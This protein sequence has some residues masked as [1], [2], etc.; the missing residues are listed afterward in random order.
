MN[1]IF[2][3]LLISDISSK[4]AKVIYFSEHDNLITSDMNSMGKSVLMKSLYHALG[5]DS[6]FDKN[7]DEQNVLFSLQ[8]RNN[9]NKYRFLR[10]KNSIATIS[11]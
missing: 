2:E 3:K 5:A 8:F 10:F 7:F 1:F 6:H 9:N 11:M 4:R